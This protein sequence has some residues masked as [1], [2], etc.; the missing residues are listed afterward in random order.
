[1]DIRS[2]RFGNQSFSQ[3]LH[4]FNSSGQLTLI[5]MNLGNSSAGSCNSNIIFD[6]R[7]P[8]IADQSM[9]SDTDRLM[10]HVIIP[11]ISL[12]GVF[13]NAALIFMVARLPELRTSL[14][15]TI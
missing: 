8:V 5:N 1:M 14:R 11:L 4:H 9:A 3:A 10:V 13:S 2:Y 15:E 12:V 7:D 6:L